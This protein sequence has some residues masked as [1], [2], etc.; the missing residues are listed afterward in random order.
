MMCVYER[1]CFEAFRIYLFW[2]TTEEEKGR[3]LFRKT[4]YQLPATRYQVPSGYCLLLAAVVLLAA[5]RTA[6]CTFCAG[7]RITIYGDGGCRSSI[8]QIIYEMNE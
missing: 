4:W 3:T 8:I 6:C 2:T 5:G 1:S 7:C